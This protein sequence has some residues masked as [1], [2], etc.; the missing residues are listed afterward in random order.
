MEDL[1]KKDGKV[2]ITEDEAKKIGFSS[3][4][5]MCN[6]SPKEA[7]GELEAACEGEETP[8]VVQESARNNRVIKGF[9][10]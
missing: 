3:G 9:G 2:K 8:H 6:E 4:G 1:I 5:T 7:E 10:V